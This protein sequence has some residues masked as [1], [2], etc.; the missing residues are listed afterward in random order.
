MIDCSYAEK[1]QDIVVRNGFSTTRTSSSKKY[2]ACRTFT[3]YNVNQDLQTFYKE[4]ISLDCVKKNKGDNVYN[5]DDD[6]VDEVK[7]KIR[8]GAFLPFWVKQMDGSTTTIRSDS[9]SSSSGDN[10]NLM[11]Y[12]YDEHMAVALYDY[13]V[14]MKRIDG[15]EASTM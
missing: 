2:I 4:I 14:Y 6:D 12:T 5:D 7:G 13:D 3:Q 10:T 15:N 9:S 11:D 1:S 8:V